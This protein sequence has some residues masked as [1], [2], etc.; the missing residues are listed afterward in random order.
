MERVA[1][2]FTEVMLSEKL[3]AVLTLLTAVLSA[4]LILEIAE[5]VSAPP[6]TALAGMPEREATK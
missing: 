1:A 6:L 2:S 4:E 3:G 5:A